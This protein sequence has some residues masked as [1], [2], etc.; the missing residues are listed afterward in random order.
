M[1]KIFYSLILFFISLSVCGQS[2]SDKQ[3]S[4][5]AFYNATNKWFSAWK[6]VSKEIYKIKKVRPVEFVFFDD[7]Y[8]YSTS[9]VTVKN[10]SPVKGNNLM[11]LKFQWK[12]ELHNDSLTLPDKSV[13]VINLMSFAAEIPAEGKSFFVMPLPSFWKQAGASSKEL[14]LENLITGVFIHEFSHSQQMQNFGKKMT[15][16][17]KQTNY[18]V[19]FNDDIVQNIF[20][21]DTAYLN[22]YKKETEL[23]YAA[24]KNNTVERSV[25]N[26]GLLLMK[27]RQKEYF[28]GKYENLKEIDNFFLTM[29]GLGQYSMF[30]WLKHPKGGNIKREM[31]IEG[32]RRGRK[33]WSQ[34][35]GFALFL[36]LDKLTVPKNWAKDMFGD[37]TESVTILIEKLNL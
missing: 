14:G 27:Q 5:L 32:V 30:L 35:E 11:N 9:A 10:G 16:F 25:V 33:W 19:E 21:K 29:E 2:K 31:A 3:E 26:E 13:V 37:K 18:G 17:E 20:A 4:Y 1:I 22:Y 12:K 23:F 28:K 36:I 6:L 15:A 8:V 24:I 34:E 7:K